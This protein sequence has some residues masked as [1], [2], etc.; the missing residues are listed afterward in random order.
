MVHLKSYMK[1]V[2]EYLKKNN[3]ERV[4]GF[5]AEAQAGAKQLLGNFKD[6]EFF[7]SES[8]NPDGQV[9]LLNYRED[10]VTPF[11]TLWKDGLRSQKI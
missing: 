2:E 11:F 7:M 6:L 10:G 1:E 5:K 9:L 8:V 3:P 4:E